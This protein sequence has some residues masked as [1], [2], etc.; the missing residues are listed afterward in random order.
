M[1][2]VCGHAWPRMATFA[3]APLRRGQAWPHMVTGI[4]IHGGAWRRVVTVITVH[5]GAWSRVIV[6]GPGS[7]QP[8]TCMAMYCDRCNGTDLG[9]SCFVTA[10]LTRNMHYTLLAGI[11]H[12]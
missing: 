10:I 1:H 6:H 5:G 7:Y 4:T 8:G 3:G 11:T 12:D 2:H 9:W